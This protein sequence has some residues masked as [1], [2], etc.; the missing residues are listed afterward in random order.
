MTR[1]FGYIRVSTAK[2]G[3][4]G[5]SLEVQ[6]DAIARYATAHGI[7]IIEWF[8]ERETAAK[9]GRPIFTR[10]VK[11]LRERRVEGV[12]IHKIDRSARNLKDWADL[13]ELIDAGVNVHFVSDNLDLTSRGGRLTADIQAVIAADYIRNLREETKKGFYGRLKQGIYPLGAPVGYLNMGGGKPKVIDPVR[14]PLVRRAFELYATRQYSVPTLTAKMRELGLANKRGTPI[15]QTGVWIM[16]QNPFYIGLLALKKTKETFQGIHEPLIGTGLF[17]RVQEILHGRNVPK[18][19]KHDFVFR[20][21]FRCETCRTTLIGERQKGH[22]YYRCHTKGCPMTSI[23]EEK[24]EE[25]VLGVLSQ[26]QFREEA[27]AI[28]ATVLRERSEQ[29][30]AESLRSR[31]LFDCQLGQITARLDRLTDAYLDQSVDKETYEEKRRRLLEEKRRVEDEIAA[32]DDSERTGDDAAERILELAN[33]ASLSYRVA[34]TG[35]KRRILDLLTSNRT[36]S[37]NHVAV[38]ASFPFALLLKESD[39]VSSALQPNAPRSPRHLPIGQTSPSTDAPVPSA[40]TDTLTLLLT[41]IADHPA[42]TRSLVA[43]HESL[44]P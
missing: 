37:P 4:Q 22:V 2:Q 12:V 5:V 35:E 9:R 44:C 13:G 40:D 32:L 24:L 16:L 19:V 15:S 21:L 26:L 38:E 10:M 14:A 11:L 34:N 36:V 33:T 23:R 17:N 31:T 18:V 30:R 41:W 8:E 29:A 27:R 3:E 6:K 20:K 1:C 42:E 7:E 28:F 39:D 25:A 43:F